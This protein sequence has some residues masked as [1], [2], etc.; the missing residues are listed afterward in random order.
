M[1][2]VRLIIVVTCVVMIGYLI[3]I[4]RRTRTSLSQ[5]ITTIAWYCMK[6]NCDECKLCR[7]DECIRY[8][9]PCDWIDSG[10]EKD[11]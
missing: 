1:M 11:D 6:H 8:T 10:G 2:I 5:A 9:V 4:E 3:Y 7:N